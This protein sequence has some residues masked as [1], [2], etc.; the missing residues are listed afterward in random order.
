MQ[1]EPNGQA[2]ICYGD[3]GNLRLDNQQAK[4]IAEKIVEELWC[5]FHPTATLKIVGKIERA[6][7]REMK[8]AQV[9]YQREQAGG[10]LPL[11]V[12]KLGPPPRL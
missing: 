5:E 12:E 9:K 4:A 6:F 10:G 3:P 2:V 7:A 11:S 1:N 8:T